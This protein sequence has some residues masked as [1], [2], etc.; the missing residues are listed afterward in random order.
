MD[1]RP[2]RRIAAAC[3]LLIAAVVTAETRP[4]TAEDLVAMERIADPQPSPD[5]RWVA[6]VLRSTDLEANGAQRDLWLV[7]TGGGD[8]PRR[9]TTDPA[10]DVEPRW[11]SDGRGIYFL[12]T[13]S[14]SVQVWYLPIDGGEARQVTRLPLDVANLVVSADGEHLAFTM[15]VFADCDDL[16]CTTGRLQEQEQGAATGRLYERLFVRH[17]DTWKD[18]RRSHLFVLKIGADAS[19]EAGPPVDVTAGFDADVPSKPFGDSSEIAFAPGGEGLVFTARDA[20]AEEPWSTDF[21][22][23]FAPID[24]SAPPRVLTDNPAWD[25]H[26]TFS[27]DGRTLAYFA[28]QRAGFEADRLRIVLRSWQAGGDREA[29]P[30]AAGPLGPPRV[31]AEDWD[32]SAGSLSFAADGKTVLVT[33]G[34]TG[35]VPLFAIDV[36]SGAVR[37]LVAEGHVRSPSVAGDRLVFGLDHLRSPVQLFSTDLDGG[38]RRQLTRANEALLAEVRMGDYEQ[39]SFAG[40]NDETVYGYVVR[41]ADLDPEVKAPVAFLIHGGPQGSFDNDF[42]Y[43]WNPQ[44][45][46]GAGYAVVMIDFHGSTG[47][48]QAFTDSIRDDWGGK[49]LEDLQKGLASALERYPWLDGDRVCALGASYGG[50]MVNWIAGNWPNR[51]RC[52]VNHDGLFDLRSMYYSTEELWF[53]EWELGGPP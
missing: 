10:A 19:R 3:W 50:Y 40:W 11:S 29:G 22:L 21:D 38:D 13:R 31:L 51:F 8:P 36:G 25:T 33:A 44:V 28:M 46:A 7:D 4:F 9:L 15:E 20:G 39:F 53:P 1:H 27:P 32:R 34:D 45:Y 16:V 23:W 2:V 47:Y 35:N 48:G 5:G 49:P 30:R 14:G 17:W 18:G 41:P 26:P 52:L 6:Y 12:S 37:K 43:R 42:H 24:G